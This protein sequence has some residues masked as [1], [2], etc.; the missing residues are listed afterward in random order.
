MNISYSAMGIDPSLRRSGVATAGGTWTV[1]SPDDGPAR[2]AHIRN[3]ITDNLAG[4]E[5]VAIEGY[6]HG[7]QYSLSALGEIGGVI[8]LA[9]WEQ[10]IVYVDVAPNTLK[11]YAL[12]IGR[13]SKTDMVIAARDRLGYEGSDD[14][15]ADALWLY[16]LAAALLDEPVVDLPK[17]HTRALDR[18]REQLA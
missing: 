8:R 5:L 14:N 12:G 9:L 17:T 15:E 6:A 4:V 7:A 11:M 16:A 10:G 2:L 18:F 1:T 13:G 3:D